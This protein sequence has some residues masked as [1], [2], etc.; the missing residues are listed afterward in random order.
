MVNR[1][2]IRA[3]LEHLRSL[4]DHADPSE[5]MLERLI[6][7]MDMDV[8]PKPLS[9][10]E[11]EEAQ[12]TRTHDEWARFRE[13]VRDG[14]GWIPESLDLVMEVIADEFNVVVEPE[15]DLETHAVRVIKDAYEY[16]DGISEGVSSP[17]LDDFR[18]V[19]LEAGED[20]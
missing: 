16:F 2:Q 13:R 12:V 9:A 3:G 15:E 8:E 4:S 14:N 20:V 17:L 7:A 1:R 5:V 19:L 11:P 18:K 6:R 10:E